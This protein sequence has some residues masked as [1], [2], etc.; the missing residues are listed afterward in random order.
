[1]SAETIEKTTTDR[2]R[3]YGLF[4][5]ATL[6]VV[7]QLA[8]KQ[9]G[10]T[11]YQAFF[12]EVG[13]TKPKLYISTQKG[14]GGVPYVDVPAK[15]KQQEGTIV[16][17]L[18]MGN[19]L[20]PNQLYQVATIA[21]ANPAYRVIAFGNPSGKPYHYREQNLSVR[22]LWNIA[23]S[24]RRHALVAAELEYLASQEVTSAYYV[25]YSYG[26]LK[27]LI[28]SQYSQGEQK[29][30]ILIDP[31]AHPRGLRQLFR[32]FNT[33]FKPMGEYVNRTQVQTFF[34]ARHDAVKLVDYSAGLT[35]PINIAIGLM[36]ARTDLAPLI[37]EVLKKKPNLELAVAWGSKSELGNDAHMKV[38]MHRLAH[39]Y[40]SVRTL[41]LEGDTHPFAN[42]IHL[43]AAIIREAL[44]NI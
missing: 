8:R 25:G 24:S 18:P 33:S 15:A 32:D 1:L 14:V 13:V 26:A 29:G 37:D 27:A 36:L 43:H 41:R 39:E 11:T 20:D 2:L 12:D 16:L 23:F 4:S 6:R 38:T 40:A 9:V 30:L 21:A 34:D 42:D 5:A 22:K 31:V 28:A 19:S 10:Y 35:R 44:S 7:S 3:R 17:H